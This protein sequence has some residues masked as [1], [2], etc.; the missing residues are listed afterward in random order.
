MSLQTVYQGEGCALY[1]LPGDEIREL[2]CTTPETRTICNDPFV[3]GVDYTQRLR[4]ACARVFH[5]LAAE[6]LWEFEDARIVVLNILRGGLNFGLR[7]ALHEGVGCRYH[8]SA[9]V[10]A[11]RA[12]S[13]ANPK[14]WVITEDAYQK[15]TLRGSTDLVFGDVVATG[16]SL[17]H[18][19]GRVVTTAV[20]QKASIESILFFTIGSARSSAILRKLV[21]RCRERFP[22]FR[23]AAVVYFEGVFRKASA[24]TP[25]SVKIDGTDLLRG[26]GVLAP[27]FL[28]SQYGNPAYPI[29]RCTIYDAGSRAFDLPEYFADVRG[30]WEANLELAADGMT[31]EQLLRQRMPE[32]DVGRYG[33]D[34]DLT[35]LARA[36]LAK[37]PRAL[38]E[39]APL[40]E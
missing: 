39:V 1:Q 3:C 34:V 18:A 29:E 9:F 22:G 21:K 37:I 16:T 14:D 19:V 15:L 7:E 6:R 4:A 20:R 40:E 2:I 28:E 31:Y 35:T 11:Q 8:N 26:G 12:R 33:E 25:M 27:E 5:V 24:D 13:S 32:I 38:H 36:Q 23:A 30:Y 17:E 10:S